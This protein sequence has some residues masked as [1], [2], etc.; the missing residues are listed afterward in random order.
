MDE[1]GKLKGK[2]KIKWYIKVKQSKIALKGYMPSE[3][4]KYCYILGRGKYLFFLGGGGWNIVFGPI[5]G[6]ASQIRYWCRQ[7]SSN[8][9]RDEAIREEQQQRWQA[10]LHR[11]QSPAPSY[12][13]TLLADPLPDRPAVTNS[14]HLLGVTEQSRA[15]DPEGVWRDTD[16]DH[17][18]QERKFSNF[19]ALFFKPSE[20]I[21]VILW[22]YHLAKAK[23]CG[24][25]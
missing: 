25:W 11:A 19:A 12:F 7:K 13:S 14:S 20:M 21:T 16:V 22:E 3:Y 15:D 18:G 5:W 8:P 23:N 24:K 10:L 1:T 17:V 6:N 9:W 2:R 4:G